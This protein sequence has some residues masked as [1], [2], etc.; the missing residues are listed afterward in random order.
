MTT[1]VS[2]II[3]TRTNMDSCFAA[4][5]VMRYVFWF[6]VAHEHAQAQHHQQT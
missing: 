3:H 5:I 1:V 6:T 4:E 2:G